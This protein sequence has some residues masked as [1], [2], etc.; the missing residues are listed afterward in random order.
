MAGLSELRGRQGIHPNMTLGLNYLKSNGTYNYGA[1][2]DFQINTAFKN[3]EFLEL[4]KNEHFRF[5][6]GFSGGLKFGKSSLNIDLGIYMLNKIPDLLPFYQRVYFK[7]CI[8]DLISVRIGLKAHAAQA[9]TLELGITKS[10][11]TK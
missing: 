4:E 6:L 9:E 3:A 11:K 10:F 2:L 8:S 7:H 1:F 5:G